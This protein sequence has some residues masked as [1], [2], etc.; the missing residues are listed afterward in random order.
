MKRFKPL[1][2][3]TLALSLFGLAGC[4]ASGTE[5]NA[6]S[7]LE[8]A[9]ERGY[10]VV[11]F[12]NEKPYAY[13][14]PDGKLTGE[15]VEVARTALKNMGI[16]EMRGELTEFASLIPGLN[17]KRFDMITAGMFINPERAK[18]V[19]FA[20]PE[21][22]IGE[23]IAVK[24]GNPL[25]IHSYEDIAANPKAKIAVPGGAI[26]YDYLLKSGVP[27]KQIMTVP[28]MPAALSAL[29]SGRADALT[30]TGPSV[31]ATLETA[32]NPDLERVMDFMQP[33][34][35]G[36]EVLGYGATAFR[37][38]DKDFR[39]AFNSELEKLKNSGELLK[40][41]SPF[42]FTEQELPGD[43]TAEELSKAAS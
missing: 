6:K 15:A 32:N 29:Q 34:I 4:G 31:Q 3:V 12:A 2:A 39:E 13:Q 37:K 18:E 19:D 38:E 26:E 42:G 36:K 20:N 7:A 27:L 25:N 14:T 1:L 43:K 9:K 35:D 11:G 33:I 22:S 24:K 41:I 40:I 10:V 30:A 8:T 5:S 17:A 16:N 21:Y 23:G 28:D